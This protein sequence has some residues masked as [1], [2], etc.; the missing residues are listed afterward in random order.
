MFSLIFKFQLLK[1]DFP[2]HLLRSNM[3][4]LAQPLVFI[5]AVSPDRLNVNPDARTAEAQ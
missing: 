1:L 5:N 4:L 3:P 2:C